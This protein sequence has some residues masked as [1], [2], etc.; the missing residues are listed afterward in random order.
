MMERGEVYSVK[1]GKAAMGVE[2]ACPVMTYDTDG[3]LKDWSDGDLNCAEAE[4][5]QRFLGLAME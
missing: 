3:W 5:N 4:R 1:G 2:V